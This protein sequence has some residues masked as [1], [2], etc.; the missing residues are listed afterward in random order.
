MVLRVHNEGRPIAPELL[1]VLFDAMTRGDTQGGQ[2]RSVGLG[3]FIVRHVVEAHGGRVSVQ[4]E[5]GAG[6]TFTVRLPRR[7]S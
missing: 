3:L 2:R 5:E 1:P 7:S 4:S 6:T